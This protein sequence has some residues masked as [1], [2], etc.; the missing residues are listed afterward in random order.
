MSITLGLVSAE[1]L[2]ADLDLNRLKVYAEM[3][4]RRRSQVDEQVVEL[5]EAMLQEVS[6][7]TAPAWVFGVYPGA[8]DGRFVWLDDGTVLQ[9][10][11]VLAPLLV[12]VSQFAV[13]AATA[14][15]AFQ[16]Y[17]DE[18]KEKG[19]VLTDFVASVIGSCI[20]EATGKHMKKVLEGEFRGM[21]YT[22]RFSPG[23][24]DWGLTEQRAL[25]GLLGGAPCGISLSE[26]CLMNPI[27]SITGV[28]GIGAE[29]TEQIYGCQLCTLET[30]YKRRLPTKRREPMTEESINQKGPDTPIVDSGTVEEVLWRREGSFIPSEHGL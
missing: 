17:Q 9:V 6:R 12:G 7:F 1:P 28:I 10:G 21:S 23:Y 5:T 26:S 18:L 16:Q 13:Y 3:G 29:L 11:G 8:V 20:A 14:G 24:C 25:F 15:A 30:C 19:D 2:L 4:Y 27:K 22:N